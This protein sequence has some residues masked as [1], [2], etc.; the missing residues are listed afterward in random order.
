[1]DSKI[2]LNGINGIITGGI[3]VEDFAVVAKTDQNI[4][5][6]MLQELAA[7]DIG[8]FDGEMMEFDDGDKLLATV[9]ALHKGV[10]IDEIAKH[11][12]WKDFEG[13]AAKV[14]DEQDFATMRNLILT[15]TRMEI[16]VVGVKL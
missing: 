14:L 1:M 3:T 7:N 12:D 10:L 16:D 8:R 2:W 13:L 4:A 9:Y 15:K 5:K 6:K 11:L